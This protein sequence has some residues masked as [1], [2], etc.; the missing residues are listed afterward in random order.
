MYHSRIDPVSPFPVLSS[1]E[2]DTLPDPFPYLGYILALAGTTTK[3][4]LAQ[5]SP[6]HQ[7]DQLN[8]L[9]MALNQFDT[10]LP[11]ELRF[12]TAT[13]KSYVPLLQG[14]AF[15]LI[16]VRENRTGNCLR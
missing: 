6:E 3:I 2:R 14:G 9:Q 16:H 5:D 1:A 11:E 7:R 4:M 10:T 13:F 15:V 12:Q 8:A